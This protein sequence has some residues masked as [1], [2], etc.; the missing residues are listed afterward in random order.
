[1]EYPG[2]FRNIQDYPVPRAVWLCVCLT[3]ESRGQS[4]VYAEFMNPAWHKRDAEAI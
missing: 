2:L 3:A 4:R 1:M